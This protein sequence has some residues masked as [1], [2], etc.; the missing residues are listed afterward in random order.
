MSTQRFADKVALITGGNSGIGRATA[1]AFAREGAKV[2]IAGRR[3]KE[4]REVVDLIKTAGGHAVFIPTDVSQAKDVEGLVSHTIQ[5]FGKLDY[6]F[7]N[8]GTETG[9][10]PMA[11]LTEAHFD[12]N[13]SVNLKGVWLCLR[14]EIPAM[15]RNQG[16]VIVNNAS[17]AGEIGLSGATI[18]GAAKAGVIGMTRAAAIEH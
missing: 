15:L 14:Y 16:G 13:M 3:V 18:Y 7:N 1:L 9:M 8:A 5:A 6:A 11:E 2:V 4:G 17:I 12:Q 10:G